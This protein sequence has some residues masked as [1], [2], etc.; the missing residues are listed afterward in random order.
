[1]DPMTKPTSWQQVRAMLVSIFIGFVISALTVLFQYAI[2]WLNQI[3][4]EVPG[5]I[6]GIVKYM[7]W[8]K[9][10]TLV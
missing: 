8:Q 6:V 4:A 3:P 5:S 9:H 7:A 10:R 1:M 2:E